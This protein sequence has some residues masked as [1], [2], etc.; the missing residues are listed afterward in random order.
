MIFASALSHELNIIL[1]IATS[2]MLIGLI[3]KRLKQPYI[4][5]YI[6]TGVLLGPSG[7]HLVTDFETA[8]LIGELGLVVLMFFIGM[9]ISLSDF[10]KKWRVA[11]FGTGMQVL[12]SILLTFTLGYFL[13][14]PFQRIL[15]LG[16]IISLS[17]SAVVIKLIEDHKLMQK[18]IGQ[19]VISILLTQDVLIVPMII[20]MSLLGGD[21]VSQE[22]I[23][24]Q[25][26][27]GLVI[28]ILLL[29]LLRKKVIKI[30]LA[31]AIADDHELQVF[32]SLVICFAFA[33][34]TSSFELSAGL[35]AFVAGL[36]INASPANHW[37]HE[38]LHSFRVLLI[39]IFFFSVGMQIDLSFLT[40]NWR[41]VAIVVLLVYLSNQGINTLAL[42]FLGN[43]WHESFYGA[44]LLAQIGEFSYVLASLGFHSEIISSYTYQITVI[45][46]S[47]T[48]FISPLWALGSKTMLERHRQSKLLK[49]R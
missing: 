29:F 33:L 40:E 19:Q 2:V 37:L 35:G 31:Q 30:P 47:I 9:E 34:F 45:V 12:F 32:A 17:S 36:F 11:F 20:I 3:L 21:G 5:A 39:S 10:I 43:S 8:E 7:F 42:R 6:L 48:I 24:L 28:F 46:I 38:R 41:A 23:L 44:S 18:N 14:W 49:G 13:D 25:L 26:S 4:I 16:F 27:G 1:G 22:L 15:L